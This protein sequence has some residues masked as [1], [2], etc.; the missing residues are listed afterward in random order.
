IGRVMVD[1]LGLGLLPLALLLHTKIHS[2]HTTV[3]TSSNNSSRNTSVA[4]NPANATTKV[5][6]SALESAASF[7][8]VLFYLAHL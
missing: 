2:N 5:V 1:R 6:G 4:T 3:K 7:L 8:L